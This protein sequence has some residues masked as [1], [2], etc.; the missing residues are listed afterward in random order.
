LFGS[1]GFGRPTSGFMAGNNAFGQ[2]V[3]SSASTT[4]SPSP[5][6]PLFGTSAFSQTAASGVSNP[7]SS[8][9]GLASNAFGSMGLGS[10]PNATATPNRN[11]FG[12]GSVFARQATSGT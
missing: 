2:T 1:S 5:A 9:L 12:G 7:G 10:M 11:V 6:Q 3:N 4:A 8:S